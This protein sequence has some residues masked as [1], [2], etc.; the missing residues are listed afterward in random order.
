M[1]SQINKTLKQKKKISEIS[2]ARISF[3]AK[4]NHVK[5]FRKIEEPKI[6]PKN[7]VFFGMTD[8]SS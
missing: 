3:V 5:I 4:F 2:Y 1:V 8:I 7:C 6:L